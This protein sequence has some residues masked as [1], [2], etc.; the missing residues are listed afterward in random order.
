MLEFSHGTVV[1]VSLLRVIRVLRFNS[2]LVAHPNDLNLALKSLRQS[3]T[4]AYNLCQF[5]FVIIFVYSLI[6]VIAFK[7]AQNI[8]PLNDNISFRN[9]GGSLILMTQIS[10]SA[11]WD[12]VYAAL[13]AYND[14]N[15]FVVFLFL[16]SFLFICILIIV[17]LVLTIILNYY[18]NAYAVET[19]SSKL[20][21]SDLNDFNEKW[22][23]IAAVDQPLFIN[24]VQL[25]IVLN[26]LN[27]SSALRSS[28]I[29]T[30]ENIQL[31]GIPI[32]NEQQ[33]YRGEVLIALN[34]ARL[35]QA[36][37]K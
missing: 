5:L 15:P 36:N 6:G 25:P 11:A 18:T 16:W 27:K 28:I 13:A 26:H 32:H 2:I 17:N 14:Y 22:K 24:K 23:S 29:P 3:K 12:G 1:S 8:I 35:R 4:A 31:L 20:Q 37:S 34:R 9:V 30:E 19:E 7:R 10:T 21:E 33:L